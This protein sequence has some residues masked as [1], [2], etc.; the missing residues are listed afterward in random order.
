MSGYREPSARWIGPP[1]SGNW[2][3]ARRGAQITKVV[4]HTIVGTTADAD[5]RFKRSGQQA[6]AHYGVGLA[7]DLAQWVEEGDTAY[8]AGNISVNLASVGIEHEDG[9]RYNDP[10][11]DALYTTSSRLVRD[12]CNR[13]QLPIDRATVRAHREVSNAPTACPDALDVERIVRMAAW[14]P[15]PDPSPITIPLGALIQ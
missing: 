12:I 11:P 3:S 8:H 10:R 4:I 5:A 13:Y 1:A 9:G 2:E 7:G 6:S 14:T 15:P